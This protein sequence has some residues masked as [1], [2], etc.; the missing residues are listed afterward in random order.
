MRRILTTLMILLAV[1]I[2]GLTA[3]VLLVNPNDFR[4]Y[5]VKE[6][7]SRSGYQLELDGPLRW[8]VW[9]Q[10]SILSGRMTLTAPG[11]EEPV[12]RADNMRLDVGLVPLLSH[13]LQ[14]K[15]VMLKGA[16]IQLTSKTEAVRSQNAPVVPH[17][18]TL[19]KVPE[20]RGWSY[21]VEK[22]Q[23]ADSVLFFQH[24]DGEQVTV[25]DIR[26]QMEQDDSHR[27]TVD[28]SGRVNRDQ[29][30]LAL[31]FS[32]LVQG[33][34]YPHSLKADFS[35]LNWQL[36]GA[37]LPPEGISGQGSM[38]ASWL[39][40][41][42][43]LSFEKLNLMANG[44]SIAGSGSVVLGAQPNWT[45][46]L[47]AGTLNLDSLLSHSSASTS[48]GDNQQNSPRQLRPVI[49]NNDIQQDY[50]SLRGFNARV[51]LTADQLQWRGMNFTQVKS[52]ISNQQGLLTV[53]QMQG[54]LDGGQL[55]LPG[56]L[57]AR[58]EVPFASFQ[59][60]LD[61]VEISSILKAFDYSINLTGKL[62]LTGEFSGAKIDADD[63]RRSW[64]GRAQIQMTDT[65]TE[66]LNFQQLVQQAVERST[67]VQAQENYDNATRLDSFNTE[68]GLDN[69][70]VTLKSMQGQSE[71]MALTGQGQLNLQK[72][73]CDMRFNVRVLGGWKGESRLIDRLKQTAIPLRIYGNW[74]TLSYSLQVD[75]ILR[76]QLQDEAK[77]RLS[78]WAERNKN[79]Q[80]GKDVKK[81]LDKL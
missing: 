55:S 53:N 34:D 30:D 49:A 18:N 19:P 38:Q 32:A 70:L 23:I 54:N 47:Q 31:S 14:V 52:D 17:D 74:Q 60:A 42:K 27:A 4:A 35:Q 41:G 48:N 50:T 72:E 5:M 25:R 21:D 33:G 29:R 62:S 76:K 40:D 46:N 75:Q 24:E 56:S 81:L 43:K 16:V 67:N 13:Q 36:R 3:L 71:L 69:G 58:G 73:D 20:D 2:A 80:D 1:V 7:A 79:T 9:P 44:S 63:F 66:G 51:T 8:H 59:P 78:E 61:K 64:Q 22:L 37:E 57:D 28:F 15:Q 11:A 6:V 12:I 26:L 77:K 68:L 10:L 65:R 39:E 45:L